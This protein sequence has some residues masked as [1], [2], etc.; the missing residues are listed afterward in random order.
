MR[1]LAAS[2]LIGS[3]FMA[4][5]ARAD[6]AMAGES[7]EPLPPYARTT[8]AEPLGARGAILLGFVNARGTST[9]VQWE[10]GRT[11]S[12]GRTVPP[13][14]LIEHFYGFDEPVDVE[15][16]VVGLRPGTTYH[17]RLVAKS[18]G[19]TTYGKDRT[20]RTRSGR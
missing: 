16:V 20:F 3:L 10:I 1:W 15:E 11:K 4:G 2:L 14:D 13:T 18:A 6:V 7:G 12:Y 17:F 5:A 19:G 8:Y 9:T